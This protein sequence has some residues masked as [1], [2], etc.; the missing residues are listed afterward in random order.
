MGEAK[1]VWALG[2]NGELVN[3]HDKD[4]FEKWHY[5]PEGGLKCLTGGHPVTMKEL[6]KQGTRFISHI[7]S[8]RGNSDALEEREL[9]E[10]LYEKKLLTLWLL[11]M[12]PKLGFQAV[13]PTPEE[14]YSLLIVHHGRSIAI[15]IETSAASTNAEA[16]ER[17]Q[18]KMNDRILA[19]GHIPLWITKHTRWDESIHAISYKS[20]TASSSEGTSKADHLN[21]LFGINQ[22]ILSVE[23]RQPGL[24]TVSLRRKTPWEDFLPDFIC[25]R[26]VFTRLQRHRGFVSTRDLEFYTQALRTTNTALWEDLKGERRKLQSSQEELERNRTR[27]ADR[28]S[29]LVATKARLEQ[30]LGT[31]NERESELR[32]AQ[33]WARSIEELRDQNLLARTALQPVP[34]LSPG[35]AASEPSSWQQVWPRM[36]A[37]ALLLVPLASIIIIRYTLGGSRLL[38]SSILTLTSLAALAISVWLFFGWCWAR[39]RGARGRCRT[40]RKHIFGRCSR[41]R[42]HA[43]NIYDVWGGLS[44]VTIIGTMLWSLTV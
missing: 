21:S 38:D 3:V 28:E 37:T 6:K 34:E 23:Q 5:A 32:D 40:K 22:G 35:A 33:A 16:R 14:R 25:G 8:A 27:V 12:F 29:E 30:Q 7:A 17:E 2:P 1:M 18:R 42:T 20:R 36:M 19:D 24:P 43:L 4:D 15:R 10:P 9:A 11:E 13:E 39:V 31:L 41:H 26:Y 44:I